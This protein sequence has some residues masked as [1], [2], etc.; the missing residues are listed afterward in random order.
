MR[1]VRAII[2]FGDVFKVEKPS[3]YLEELESTCSLLRDMY[4]KN[5]VDE[6]IEMATMLVDDFFKA[7]WVVDQMY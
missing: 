5:S 6:E 2:A 3:A 7:F 4:A 1:A